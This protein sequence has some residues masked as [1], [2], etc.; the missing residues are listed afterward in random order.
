M[1]RLVWGLVAVGVLA[2]VLAGGAV[3]GTPGG[4]DDGSGL[5]VL[6]VSD[7]ARDVGGNHHAPAVGRIDG[8][9]Y[10]FA[11][12]SGAHRSSGCALVAL[13]AD[14]GEADWRHAVPASNCTIHSVGDPALAD[15]DADG[16]RELL[17][18][19]TER[20]V[21]AFDPANGTVEAAGNL[22]SYG[23]AP[24]VVGDL[25]GGPAPEVA[26]ADARGTV[27]LLDGDLSTVRTRSFDS[28]TYGRPTL[29]DFDAD[30][31]LEL[32]VAPG[33]RGV[34]LLAGDGSVVWER[35]GPFES[36]ITW[37]TA[38][39]LDADP[40]VEFVAATRGGRVVALDGREGRVEW[41]RDLGDLAAVHAV[42]DGDGDGTRE[43]YAA[44]DGRIHALSGPDGS[45]EWTRTLARDV[46]MTPPPAL[47]DVTG[48]GRPDLLAPTNDGRVVLIDPADGTV[49][50]AYRRDAAV[51]THP[52]LADTDGDGALEAFV[53]YGDGRVV[54]LSV[55]ER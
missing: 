53:M 8:K 2:A 38:A 32:A 3:L 37:S 33:Q 27:H 22:S 21:L 36:S 11:P 30:G 9:G 24:P 41:R 12:V 49:I 1:R 16:R 14:D 40:A 26:V 19:T 45:T 47:G 42:G 7:T 35:P 18:A 43:V 44:A 6:W 5:R 50:D 54:A 20:R 39:D 51:F 10:V 55:D 34:V 15:A 4:G 17:A 52:T 28:F 25:T 46:A 48:D 13:A 31:A 23:Y 29:R